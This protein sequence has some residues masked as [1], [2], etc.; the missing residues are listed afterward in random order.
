VGTVAHE[1]I[2]LP[3]PSSEGESAA[4]DLARVLAT[5]E[6]TAR[7]GGLL[8]EVRVNR[9]RELDGAPKEPTRWIDA[10]WAIGLLAREVSGHRP[11][12]MLGMHA[13]PPRTTL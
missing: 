12:C 5:R 6:D 10:R 8:D 9:L 7:R 13:E 1:W 4:V 11:G 2:A 3:P